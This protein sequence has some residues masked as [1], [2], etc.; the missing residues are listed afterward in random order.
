MTAG[1]AVTVTDP[2]ISVTGLC[3]HF[4][5]GSGSLGAAW[6]RDK[7]VLRA[8]DD[9]TITVDRNETLGVI[10]ESGSGKTTLG[11]SMLRIVQPTAGQ[12]VFD[13]QDITH[14]RGRALRI[15]RRRMQMVFQN[16]YSAVNR[17]MRIADIVAE[18]L[19]AHQVGDRRQRRER[20]LD[21]LGK[22][23]LS[24]AFAD[25]YPHEVSGGQLQRVGIARALVLSP[26]LLVADEPTASLDV[27]VSA[28]VV[29]LLADLKRQFGL[30]LVFISHDLSTVSYLADR[31][32]VL[33]LGKIVEIGPR[34]PLER[35]P[36]H[37]Y[38]KGL[39]AAIPRADPAVRTL[40]VPPGEIPSPVDPPSGCHYHPRCPL[41]M[42]V[43]R[44]SYPVLEEKL[45]GRRAA[46]HAVV[47]AA[48]G[49]VT[50]HPQA[51]SAAGQPASTT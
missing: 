43:C 1:E 41:A 28:Q 31:I 8:V 39:I 29:N 33:Y 9:I 47:A 27:S 42:P 21:L 3:H 25:R 20:A 50:T 22:V 35:D 44:D 12:I 6:R 51:G 10:G 2:L 49:T 46:C 7:P 15:L 16:P 38:T 4:G 34:Q 30:T 40:P 48:D 45:P 11:R 14:L 19:R 5:A 32:A 13:G 17:R 18:P 36:L 26:D 23:G 24:A 37:P